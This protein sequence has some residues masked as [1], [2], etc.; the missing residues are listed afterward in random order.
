MKKKAKTPCGNPNFDSAA[1]QRIVKLVGSGAS[2]LNVQCQGI[3]ACLK[4]ANGT[5]TQA[6]L[7]ENLNSHIETVQ[8]AKRIYMFYRKMLIEKGVIVIGAG[9][10]AQDAKSAKKVNAGRSTNADGASRLNT[11]PA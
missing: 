7:V 6:E 9:T 1:G 2:D 4:K 3:I 10:T 8:T 11:K 5:M